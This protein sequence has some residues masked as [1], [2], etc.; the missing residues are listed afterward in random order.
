MP[1]SFVSLLWLPVRSLVCGHRDADVALD[2]LDG[3]AP[4]SGRAL[5][6]IRGTL[7]LCRWVI[8]VRGRLRDP[9]GCQPETASKRRNGGQHEDHQQD[10]PVSPPRQTD[11]DTENEEE[12][13]GRKSQRLSHDFG[14]SCSTAGFL[15]SDVRSRIGAEQSGASDAGCQSPAVTELRDASACCTKAKR[16]KSR[17]GDA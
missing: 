16:S 1:P 14:H 17:S 8:A 13:K 15:P 3:R 7:F 10:G 6:N 11:Q 5:V 9:H 2:T 4:G 12:R